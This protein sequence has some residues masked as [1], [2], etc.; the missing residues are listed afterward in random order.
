MPAEAGLRI[1]GATAG[2]GV[3]PINAR[4]VNNHV[5]THR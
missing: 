3:Q 4:A 2:R 5:I 1:A